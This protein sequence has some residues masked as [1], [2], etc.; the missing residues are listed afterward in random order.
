MNTLHGV[1]PALVTPLD[2][3]GSLNEA[4]LAVLLSRL[5]HRGCHWAYVVGNTGEG[6]LLSVELREQLAAEV[7]RLTP[8][9]RSV[10][11][12]IG[13]LNTADSV[14]LARHAAGIGATA[15]SSLP[16]ARPGG[17]PSKPSETLLRRGGGQW[18][19]AMERGSRKRWKRYLTPKMV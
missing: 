19:V 17:L 1:L 18:K 5:Y 4:A 16:P 7:R 13:T 2:A 8:P 11:V 9:D 12:H 10:V 6:L 3:D 14:R 15:I